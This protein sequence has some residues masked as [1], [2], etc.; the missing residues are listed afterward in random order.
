METAA[1]HDFV[2]QWLNTQ[3]PVIS[4][5]AFIQAYPVFANDNVSKM[6]LE[7]IIPIQNLMRQGYGTKK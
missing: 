7:D 2:R 4:V 3:P 1:L 6:L 5:D